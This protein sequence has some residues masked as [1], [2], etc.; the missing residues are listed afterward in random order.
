MNGT[1]SLVID[2]RWFVASSS[3]SKV[4]NGSTEELDIG[5]EEFDLHSCTSLSNPSPTLS[6]SFIV[7]TW[8]KHKPT[9]K[10]RL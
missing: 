6:T 2:I 3:D 10:R 1:V 7:R 5:A 4:A 9:L 8:D